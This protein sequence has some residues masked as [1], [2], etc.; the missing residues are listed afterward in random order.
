VSALVTVE[1]TSFWLLSEVFKAP[2]KAFEVVFGTER[3]RAESR[4]VRE[5]PR[6]LELVEVAF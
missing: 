5:A 1:S 4:E 3:L 2:G 6:L